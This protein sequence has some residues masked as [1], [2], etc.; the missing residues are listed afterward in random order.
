MKV[1]GRAGGRRTLYSKERFKKRQALESY[2]R[3]PVGVARDWDCI[4]FLRLLDAHR[5]AGF[6]LLLRFVSRTSA[7]NIIIASRLDLGEMASV[8]FPYLSPQ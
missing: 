1:S 8:A 2:L 3:L 5:R 7:L 6:G 4:F